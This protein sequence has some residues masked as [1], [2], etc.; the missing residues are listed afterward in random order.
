MEP[1]AQMVEERNRAAI[2]AK[3]ET[4]ECCKVHPLPVPWFG[5]DGEVF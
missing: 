5:L 4:Y 1:F 3:G 2:T